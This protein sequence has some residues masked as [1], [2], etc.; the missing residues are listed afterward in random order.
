MGL[1]GER[2]PRNMEELKEEIKL[3]PRINPSSRQHVKQ[4]GFVRNFD[5][6]HI[7]KGIEDDVNILIDEGYLIEFKEND[8]HNDL[9]KNN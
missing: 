3:W 6:N 5:F 7:Y 2:P 1:L 4:S 8:L 9:Q